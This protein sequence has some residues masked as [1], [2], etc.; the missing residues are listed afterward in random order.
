LPCLSR[1]SPLLGEISTSAGTW[2]VAHTHSRCEKAVAQEL[3]RREIPFYLPMAERMSRSGGRRY[4]V[5][6]PL[7]RGYLFF[8]GDDQTP[9]LVMGTRKVCKTMEVV[10][11]ER[12]CSELRAIEM[13]LTVQPRLEACSF[14]VPG[15]LCRVRSGPLQGVKGKVLQRGRDMLIMLEVATL[16]Q[17]V[18]FEIDGELLEPDE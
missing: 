9:P 18:P 3:L 1:L 8:A 14:A 4:L 16:G 12:L 7:F 2:F 6:E 15:R 17:Y 11:Q 10:Q 13:A 5:D